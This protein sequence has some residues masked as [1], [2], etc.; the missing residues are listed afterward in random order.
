[1]IPMETKSACVTFLIAKYGVMG[2]RPPGSFQCWE[3]KCVGWGDEPMKYANPIVA[4]EIHA[5]EMLG[6]SSL[7]SKSI[8]DCT[9][10]GSVSFR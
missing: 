1:V 2:I 8:M 9:H 5:R 7:S 10:I 6:F 3:Q 4:A